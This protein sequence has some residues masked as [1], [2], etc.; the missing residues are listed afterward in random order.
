MMDE[1]LDRAAIEFKT[2]RDRYVVVPLIYKEGTLTPMH[3][4]ITY[5]AERRDVWNTVTAEGCAVGAVVFARELIGKDPHPTF[6]QYCEW[7]THGISNNKTSGGA[8]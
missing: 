6:E 4:E 3:E 8:D 2:L 1:Q 7:R 5:L